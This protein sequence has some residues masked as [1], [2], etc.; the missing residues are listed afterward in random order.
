MN[1]DVGIVRT[2]QGTKK[3]WLDAGNGQV[4]GISVQYIQHAETVFAMTIHKSQGS[5]YNRVLI[6]MP[7]HPDIPILTR[8]LLY[9]AVTRAKQQAI[10]VSSEVVLKATAAGSVQRASGITHRMDE[11]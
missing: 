1:G 3:L 7:N 11:L 2:I 6:R 9:T 5:E 4:R 8:E 10:I